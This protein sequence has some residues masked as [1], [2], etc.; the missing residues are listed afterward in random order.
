MGCQCVLYD[1]AGKASFSNYNFN[2][3][4]MKFLNP[5]AGRVN[6]G[7]GPVPARTPVTAFFYW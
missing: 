3:A 6:V 1:K 4:R 7:A 5:A 2:L